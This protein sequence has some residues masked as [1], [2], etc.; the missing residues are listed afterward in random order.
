MI[1]IQRELFDFV[2]YFRPLKFSQKSAQLNRFFSTNHLFQTGSYRS[3]YCQQL[4]QDHAVF[5]R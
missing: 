1:K 3:I 4:F 5:E 2:E